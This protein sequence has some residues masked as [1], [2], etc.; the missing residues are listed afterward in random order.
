MFHADVDGRSSLAL[1]AIEAV[2][3]HVDYW[4][5]AFL[6]ASAFANRDFTELPDGEVRL[7]HPLNS[8]LAHTAALWRMVCEPVANWLARS[9]GRAAGA[10]VMLTDDRQAIVRQST[11]PKQVEQALKLDP[12][13]P[14]P[15]FSGPPRGRRPMPL[16]GVLKDNPA[17][18][19]CWECGK[20][21]V[22]K[23]LRFCSTECAKVFPVDK[24]Y[25]LGGL[26]LPRTA[27]G[28]GKGT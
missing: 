28:D 16:Q 26:A 19:A 11:S 24:L 6:A 10:G 27:A 5:L 20:A 2:R 9:F 17:P 3:P 22:G 15:A 12:L 18:V 8:H 14:L 23:R 7:S 4:L 1:D 21:L 25:G 13:P